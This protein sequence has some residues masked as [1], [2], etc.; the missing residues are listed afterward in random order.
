MGV[1]SSDFLLVLLLNLVRHQHFSAID[2]FLMF[3]DFFR[4]AMNHKINHAACQ[5]IGPDATHHCKEQLWIT[6][7]RPEYVTRPSD[8]CF[9]AVSRT[10]T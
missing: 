2:Q 3:Y 8:I 6:I 9:E 1:S 5:L 10:L 4:V 7:L